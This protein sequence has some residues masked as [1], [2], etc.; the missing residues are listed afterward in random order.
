MNTVELKNTVKKFAQLD[1]A[2]KKEEQNLR[3]L[4]KVRK[5]YSDSI[6]GYLTQHKKNKLNMASHNI[7][8]TLNKTSVKQ[9]LTPDFLRPTLTT[10]F[11]KYHTDHKAKT[12][13]EH[14]LQHIHRS[15]GSTARYTLKRL[16]KKQLS[17][18][19]AWKH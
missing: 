14:L 8:L 17:A 11:Q 12:M 16:R 19:Q 3:Q 7:F 9:S 10:F 6:Q 5:T 1:A 18:Q 15:R 13:A 4:R 2:I